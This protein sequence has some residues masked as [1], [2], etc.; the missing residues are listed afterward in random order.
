MS[1]IH[2]QEGMQA[3]EAH[4][5]SLCYTETVNFQPI[6]EHSLLHTKISDPQIQE[7]SGPQTFQA[8]HHITGCDGDH[9]APARLEQYY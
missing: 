3:A 8:T 4:T 5:L 2:I 1:H 6:H 7:V 9:A